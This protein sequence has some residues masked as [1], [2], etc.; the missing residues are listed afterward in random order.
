MGAFWPPKSNCFQAVQQKL[1]L[2][3]TPGCK[4]LFRLYFGSYTITYII[5]QIF[6]TGCLNGGAQIRPVTGENGR[7]LIA[8]LETMYNQLD[9]AV[10]QQNKLIR[11][12][13]TE[14]LDGKDSDKCKATLHTEY[15]A[16]EKADIALNIKW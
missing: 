10:P 7:E 3:Y 5:L 8:N 4:A 16:V 11:T 9:L 14:W 2:Y 12:L 15:H 6:P 1:Y 13:Y